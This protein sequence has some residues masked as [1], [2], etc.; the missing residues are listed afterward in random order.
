MQMETDEREGD[1]DGFRIPIRGLGDVCVDDVLMTEGRIRMRERVVGK[2]RDTPLGFRSSWA[3]LQAAPI[4]DGAHAPIAI[5][6][7]SS[8]SKNL[9]ADAAL[10]PDWA[11]V[12]R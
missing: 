2:A 3:F 8:R 7:T 6:S 5:W 4:E 9:V 11:V 1:R 12:G 10:L